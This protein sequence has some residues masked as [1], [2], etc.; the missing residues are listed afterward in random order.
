MA[1]VSLALITIS[2]ATSR[3]TTPPD[4]LA[5]FLAAISPS[6]PKEYV[7]CGFVVQGFLVGTPE[8]A[9]ANEEYRRAQDCAIEAFENKQPFVITTGTLGSSSCSVVNGIIGNRAGKIFAVTSLSGQSVCSFPPDSLA[10]AP[11][12]H[13]QPCRATVQAG[14]SGRFLHCSP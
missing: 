4:P 14:A 13:I 7:D 9:K 10:L 1:L 6:M 8:A 11:A 12:V 2:C 5:R 3:S